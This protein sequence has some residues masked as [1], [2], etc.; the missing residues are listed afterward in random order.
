MASNSTVPVTRW[1][2]TLVGVLT[3]AGALA[4]AGPVAAANA[5]QH[6][7]PDLPQVEGPLDPPGIDAFELAQ[8]EQVEDF[9]YTYD[10]YLVSGTA[11]GDSYRVRMLI[12]RPEDLSEFSGHSIIEPKHPIGVPFVWNFTRLYLMPRGHGSVELTTFP[13]SITQLR[14]ANPERYGDLHVSSA[15][16]S[17]IYAQVGRLLHSGQSP[18]PG[19][20]ALYMTGHSVASGPVWRFADTHHDRFRLEDG[21]PIIDAFFPETT[22]TAARLG[23]FPEVD[24]PTL[25]I[26]SQL[27]VEVIFAEEGIDYR[28]PD[29]KLFRLYEVAGMPHHDSKE[30]PFYQ[31]EPCD[32]PLNRFPYKPMVSMALDHLIRWVDDGVLPPHADRISVIGGAGGEIEFDE[33]GNAVGGVRTTYVDVP[34]A[35]HSPLNSGQD[36]NCLPLGSQQLFSADK[37]FSLYGRHANY[38]RLV[39]K[40]LD[41][42]V[43][44]RWYLPQF[45]QDVR[46]EAAE[47]DGFEG[48][49]GP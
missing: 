4:I 9:G 47:F 6:E 34:H 11:A 3:L 17:D 10:E 20:D 41:K 39:N 12:A 40:R 46:T 8:P 30:N 26:N 15:Q 18:L 32:E 36:P 38:V 25:W 28:R 16:E 48:G 13:Q 43:A 29:S 7:V 42:L 44:K 49:G 21:S 5:S 27:E 45:A 37:L 22:R 19:V 35:M 24:V 33:H 14:N 31:H 1:A 2:T 23:P